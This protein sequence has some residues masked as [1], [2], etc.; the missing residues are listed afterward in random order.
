MTMQER[1]VLLTAAGLLCDAAQAFR[2]RREE[3]E[4][5]RDLETVGRELVRL[6]QASQPQAGPPPRPA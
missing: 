5:A 4:L 3:A 1:A 2:R 6:L